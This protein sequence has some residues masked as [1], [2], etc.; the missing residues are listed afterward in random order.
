MNASPKESCAI[1]LAPVISAGTTLISNK[2]DKM[3][4]ESFSKEIPMHFPTSYKLSADNNPQNWH[5]SVDAIAKK[6]IASKN[7]V[8]ASM[9]ESNAPTFVNAKIV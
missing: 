6:R 3:H 5:T 7:T 8:N 2:N 1:L 4:V 9:Q